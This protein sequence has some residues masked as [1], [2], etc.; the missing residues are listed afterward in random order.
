MMLRTRL[1]PLLRHHQ[2]AAPRRMLS[3]NA[4]TDA[5]TRMVVQAAGAGSGEAAKVAF[6]SRMVAS[7]EKEHAQVRP[8]PLVGG[9]V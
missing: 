6:Y 7:M 5:L 3:S 1:A 8:H 9:W 4:D 2:A